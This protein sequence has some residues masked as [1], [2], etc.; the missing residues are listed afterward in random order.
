MI[1]VICIGK[2]KENYLKEMI[3]DYVMRI[4]KY[5]KFEI[6]ELKDSNIKDEG[7]E[8]LKHINDKDTIISLAI[9]GQE[10]NTLEFKDMLEKMLI[11]GK[12]NITFVIGGSEGICEEIKKKS[13]FLISFSKMT[14]PHGLFRALLVEQ[15]YRVFKIINGETYHK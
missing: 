8:I 11:S 6:I 7:K 9:E 12:S 5:H 1:K 10:K 15:I 4:R 3:E 2:L 14:F 13:D